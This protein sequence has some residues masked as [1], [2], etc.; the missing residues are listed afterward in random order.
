MRLLQRIVEM[1][2]RPWAR[3]C[4]EFETKSGV[5]EYTGIAS[6]RCAAS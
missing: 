1:E 3:L 6:V 4:G 2:V 5:R